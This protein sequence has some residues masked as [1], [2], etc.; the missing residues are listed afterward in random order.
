LSGFEFQKVWAAIKNGAEQ[1]VRD[2]RLET[3]SEGTA[4]AAAF[5]GYNSGA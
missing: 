1:A 4:Y 5:C 3:R 2:L